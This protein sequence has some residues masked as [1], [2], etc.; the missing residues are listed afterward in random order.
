MDGSGQLV[1][2]VPSQRLSGYVTMT[3]CTSQ[4]LK[5]GAVAEG[6]TALLVLGA[7]ND[8]CCVY[9]KISWLRIGVTSVTVL[10]QRTND[11]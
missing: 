4:G 11:V 3:Y 8:T 5:F 2:M 7:T 1:D 10:G 9:H 6:A